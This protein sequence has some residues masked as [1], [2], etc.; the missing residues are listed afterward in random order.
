M[1]SVIGFVKQLLPYTL[2]SIVGGA[3][4]FG[5]V[6]YEFLEISYVFLSII[7]ISILTL[8]HSVVM[9][10]FYSHG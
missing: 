10:S 1:L 7:L 2:L 9:N 5:L 6:S 4:L 8:P 3:L